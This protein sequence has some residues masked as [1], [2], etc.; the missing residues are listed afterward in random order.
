MIISFCMTCLQIN[1]VCN[2][3]TQIKE[4]K[5]KTKSC[6]NHEGLCISL[7]TFRKRPKKLFNSS[8]VERYKFWARVGSKIGRLKTLAQNVMIPTKITQH[9]GS[10]LSRF[11]DKYDNT[12]K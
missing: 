10:L 4:F 7:Y 12:K 1:V 6:Q 9:G 8:I 11:V 3:N 5:I 2:E